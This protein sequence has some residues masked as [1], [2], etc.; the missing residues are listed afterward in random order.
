VDRILGGAEINLI[1]LI[2]EAERH[3]A[4]EIAVA[5]RKHSPLSQML[6]D[7]RALQFDY[8]F[9]DRLNRLRFAAGN[10]PWSQIVGGMRALQ[11]AR[12]RLLSIISEFKPSAVISCANKDH[13]VVSR[14]ARNSFWWVNDLITGDFFSF[15]TRAAFRVYS[16]GAKQLVAV[17]QSVKDSL[18]T[19]GIPAKKL[20]VIHNGIPIKKYSFGKK[21]EFRAL[22]KIPGDDPIFGLVGRVCQWKGHELF[23]KVATAWAKE[24]RPGRFVMI[25][26]P[27]NE[28]A[29]FAH[30][31]ERL[32]KHAAFATAS[33]HIKDTFAD[34]DALLHTS[35]RPE[36]FGRVIIEA[37]AA[38]VPVIAADAA[39][40]REIIQHGVNGFLARVGDADDYKEKLKL[41]NSHEDQ[42]KQMV[43]NARATVQNRFTVER[44]FREF[45]TLL[46]AASSLQ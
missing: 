6:N 24:G 28:D 16:R 44:V 33:S 38:G 2:E 37:M 12:N 41:A 13:F 4:W 19:L 30:G 1:E 45:D 15:P 9:D 18:L 23:E 25:G 20:S 35:L 22:N 27:F 26:K 29:S 43:A 10:F 31:L 17:S 3:E 8:G 32:A 46:S 39:G 40:V 5:C 36:P 14:I 42:T 34:L 11:L 21:G 7:L